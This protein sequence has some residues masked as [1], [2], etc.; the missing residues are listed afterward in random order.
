MQFQF[1]TDSAHIS[2]TVNMEK[3]TTQYKI[4]AKG[5]RKYIH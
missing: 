5:R 1:R 3:K 2:Q 4:L